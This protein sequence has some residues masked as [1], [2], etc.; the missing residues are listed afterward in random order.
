MMAARAAALAILVSAAPPAFAQPTPLRYQLSVDVPVTAVALG[1]WI[2]TEAFKGDLAPTA[3]KWCET[4]R[5]DGWMRDQVVWQDAH[6]AKRAS[7]LIAFGVLPAAAAANA[8]LSANAA[9]DASQGWTDLLLITEAVSI[10]ADLNQLVKFTVARQRPF[11]HYSTDPSRTADPDDNLSFYSGHTSLA[12]SLAAAAGTVSTMRGY[13]SAPWV[14]GI[15]MG[16]AAS[17][18]YFRMAGDMHYF[19]DVL[20]GAVVGSAIGWAVPHFLHGPEN[21]STTGA[22]GR[23]GAKVFPTMGGIVIVF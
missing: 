2:G 19:T 11:V 21:G 9:G 13:K 8:F 3:C 4:D 6:G 17:V 7:D 22:T 23:T 1:L 16:L 14:W 18:A 20:V 15:G 12:F 5:L 10:A